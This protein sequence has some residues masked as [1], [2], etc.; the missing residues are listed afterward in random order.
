MKINKI[1]FINWSKDYNALILKL[2]SNKKKVWGLDPK[3]IVKK[4]RWRVTSSENHLFRQIT[5]GEERNGFS[6]STERAV[7]QYALIIIINVLWRKISIYLGFSNWN[8]GVSVCYSSENTFELVLLFESNRN[9]RIRDIK[10]KF[11][12]ALFCFKKKKKGSFI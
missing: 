11:K 8:L 9:G 6:L 10:N 12:E 2:W 5:Y 7:Y 1:I 3:N 4:L